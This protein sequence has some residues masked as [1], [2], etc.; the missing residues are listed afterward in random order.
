VLRGLNRSGN[1]P[2]NIRSR[3]TA[4]AMVG[5]GG[6][7]KLGG[8]LNLRRGALMVI[9]RLGRNGQCRG[10]G[11]VLHHRSRDGQNQTSSDAATHRFACR[12]EV[13][14]VGLD[15]ATHHGESDSALGRIDRGL[16][17]SP[18]LAES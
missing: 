3:S 17:P 7:D 13:R 16:S 5:V 10:F 15:T 4:R 6:A 18:A 11:R 14:H 8:W 2:S 9:S 12:Q 1:R